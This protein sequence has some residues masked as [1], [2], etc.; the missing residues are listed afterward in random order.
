MKKRLPVLLLVISLVLFAAFHL[1]FEVPERP[2]LISG[3]GGN[4]QVSADCTYLPTTTS[5][6]SNGEL[7][8]L[9]WNIYKQNRDN[10]QHVLSE[11]SR[12][13]QLILL[14]EA[15]Q[16]EALVSWA[17]LG[18][19]YSDAVQ[20]F[21]VFGRSAGVNNLARSTALKRCPAATTEPWLRLPKSGLYALYSLS[22]GSRL[23]VLNLHAVNFAFGT[24]EYRQQITAL[25]DFTARHKGPLILAGDFNSWSEARMAVLDEVVSRLGLIAATFS[26]DQRTRFVN[27][28]PLDHLFY[29][30]L[31][32]KTAEASETD[33]S[34][35][36]PLRVRFELSELA[37]P[38]LSEQGD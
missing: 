29:R 13:S 8:L 27:G 16:T 28:L 11:L 15:S 30:G 35:H 1:I 12:D 22:D 10:W 18:G 17:E 32:L 36:N 19:W 26:P 21:T 9:V 24:T 14:Q 20:A 31:V 33:A 3:Q 4:W 2:L 5:L 25:A 37:A 34:D 23:A 6:D 7:N 38:G